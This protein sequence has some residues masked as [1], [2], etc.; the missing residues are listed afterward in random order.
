MSSEHLDHDPYAPL[1]PWEQRDD[2]PD[3]AYHAFEC[4]YALPPHERTDLKAYRLHVGREDAQVVPGHVKEWKVQYDW[5][6]RARAYWRMVARKKVEARTDAYVEKAAEEGRDIA[7]VET[8]WLDAY[9][10]GWQKFMDIVEDD[11]VR[12]TY[13]ARDLNSLFG[14]LYEGMALYIKIREARGDPEGVGKI[15]LTQEQR[16]IIFGTDDEEED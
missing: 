7:E 4:W 6:A 13:T 11:E 8:R 1:Y 16:E 5:V 15:E 3:S 9:L 10:S 12:K 2:E 14:R